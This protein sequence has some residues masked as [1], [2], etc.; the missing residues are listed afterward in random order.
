MQHTNSAPHSAGIS[1]LIGTLFSYSVI[2]QVNTPNATASSGR[3]N[4][5]GYSRSLS[6]H[7]MKLSRYKL[8]GATHSSGIGATFCV[9]W[10]VTASNRIEAQAASPIHKN[11]SASVG[12]DAS[13]AAFSGAGSTPSLLRQAAATHTAA[14]AANPHDHVTAWLCRA[15]R[16][17]TSVG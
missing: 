12:A 13:P 3:N 10:L 14:N 6:K 7:K 1:R 2:P 11:V 4:Q 8:N 15:I 5:R 9:K 16:G 17:S